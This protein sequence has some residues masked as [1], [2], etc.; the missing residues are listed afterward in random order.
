[1]EQMETPNYIPSQEIKGLCKKTDCNGVYNIEWINGTRDDIS[2]IGVY[3]DDLKKVGHITFGTIAEIT[4]DQLELK[5]L[6]KTVKE[7]QKMIEELKN[8]MKD[9]SIIKDYFEALNRFN[10]FQIDEQI[11]KQKKRKNE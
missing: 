9:I 3:N 7:Q 4:S 1:M 10:K 8:E 2:Y 6:R 5:K 11:E